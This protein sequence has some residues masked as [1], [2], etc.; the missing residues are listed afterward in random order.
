MRLSCLIVF[1]FSF[2]IFWGQNNPENRTAEFNQINDYRFTHLKEEDGLADNHVWA[3]HMDKQGFLWLGT[4]DGL[5]RYDG[6]SFLSF[7]L[8]PTENKEIESAMIVD[9]VEDSSGILW[10]ASLGDGLIR[11]DPVFETFQAFQ[12]DPQNPNSISGNDVSCLLLDQDGKIWVGTYSAGFNLF[13]PQSNDFQRYNLNENITSSSE[14]FRLNSIHEMLVDPDNDVVK[15]F[16]ANNGLYR[17]D[18][19]TQRLRHFPSSAPNT[20]GM[21]FHALW[22][23][24]ESALWVGAWGG[25]VCRFNT[26]QE[27]WKYYPP[28][29]S[30]WN[31]RNPNTNVAFDIVPK[32]PTELW[33]CTKDQGLLVFNIQ[34]KKYSLVPYGEQD[35][36]RLPENA[37]RKIYVDPQSRIW[38]LNFN[39]GISLANPSNDFFHYHPIQS[40]LCPAIKNYEI[41]DFEWDEKRQVFYVTYTGCE[42]LYVFDKNYQQLTS[43]VLESKTNTS[44]GYKSIFIDKSGTIWLGGRHNIGHEAQQ[45]FQHSLL[46]YHPEKNELIPFELSLDIDIQ[47]LDILDIIEDRLGR[48][49][50]ATRG[51]GLLALNK[52]RTNLRQFIQNNDH[53]NNIKEGTQIYEIVEDAEGQIWLAT[54]ASGVYRFDPVAE[55]F[56]KIPTPSEEIRSIALDQ[57]DR[58][59]IG[60]KDAAIVIFDPSVSLETPVQTL[61]K[62]DGLAS[63]RITKIISDKRGDVWIGTESGLCR[64]Q[65]DSGK[66]L[67]FSAKDGL[68]DTYLL[69]LGLAQF[70][71]GEMFVGQ[72]TGFYSFSPNDLYDKASPA[73]LAITDI[74]S[75]ETSLKREKNI[76][77][78][79]EIVLD[80]SENFFSIDFILLDYDLI[81]K[82]QY[83]YRLSE[84]EDKWV[85]PRD[86]RT[87]ATYTNVREG[88]YTFELKAENALNGTILDSRQLKIRILPPWYRSWWAYT[89]YAS[90]VIG[91][92]VFIFW[93][94][95]RRTQL[96][97]QR[98]IE[99]LELQSMKELDEMK[100]RFF[101]NISH[102]FRTP[103]TIIQGLSDEVIEKIFRIDAAIILDRLKTIRRNSQ[104]LLKLVNQILDLAKLEAQAFQPQMVQGDIM[105]YMSY[106]VKSFHSLAE[107]RNVELEINCS[108][109]SF[110]MDY[111]PDRLRDIVNNLLS[112]AIKFTPEGGKVN[113]QCSVGS[114]QSAVGN[115]LASGNTK[116]TNRRLL[117]EN[118][119]L[120]TI[121]DTGS[122]IPK[123]KLAHVFDR[124]F[125]IETS[126]TT[127]TKGTGIG[128]ALC[129]ELV[130][131]FGGEISVESEFGRGATF[132]VRLPVTREA[133]IE[134]M[135]I[136][137]PV[138]KEVISEKDSL[139]PLGKEKEGATSIAEEDMPLVLLVED[140]KDVVKYLQSCLEDNYRLVTANNGQEGIDKALNLI[141]DLIVSD[142]MM[143]KKD[144]FQLTNELKQDDKTSHIPIV[145]LTA[146][147]AIEDKLAGLKRGADAYLTKP[148]HKEE[149]LVRIQGLLQLRQQL[150]QRYANLSAIS[151]SKDAATQQ[152]DNFLIKF[153]KELIPRLEDANL[154]VPGL[155]EAMAMSRSQLHRK[156]KAVT[157]Y[158][159]NAYIRSF[160][161]KKGKQM[162]EESDMSISEIAYSIGFN[163]PNYFSRVFAKAHGKRPTEY[164]AS[165]K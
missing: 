163:D 142:V 121:S 32:S 80:Y 66:I 138:F 62:S 147:A 29:P 21:S 19:Q 16:A 64:Y 28:N 153:H 118:Y 134:S 145:M 128:L 72:K 122:G 52:E 11:F 5:S 25:G 53:A 30:E 10:L 99:A 105:A 45:K 26:K 111:D 144:G 59:W 154:D 6:N 130:E 73:S 48:L 159:T 162:L 42:G 1:L 81:E 125:Q 76:N 129:K 31:A 33:V 155:A 7:E 55:K 158:S 83:A 137:E 49:W 23:A 95:R 96:K 131:L 160:R 51:G 109:R 50:F 2:L 94:L 4:P 101:A 119:L 54:E 97:H 47:N 86:G 124:F 104:Q 57:I 113:V 85:R 116:T 18:T 58:I 123:E 112:N 132:I 98:E 71:T 60:M 141:P 41:S 36:F 117:T 78:T 156:L 40:A 110:M 136:D 27:T 38:V 93:Q 79:N 74:K 56:V 148:F 114:S 68:K 151:P 70:S 149:L 3:A 133:N 92:I 13:D 75:F 20:S 140:N 65:H 161:L 12:H 87:S 8:M 88:T 46:N 120:L 135:T 77:Y 39:E 152:E 15:W 143:P 9:I 164:R 91:L 89:L 69:Q 90:L 106:L 102:E 61:K 107:T 115:Q 103:L 24:G 43:P 17:F 67:T 127:K 100:T 84:Y 157:G 165:L 146:R 63:K 14:A 22:S 150:R 35:P 108:K 82:H 126:T 34:T 44:K 37:I 139:E